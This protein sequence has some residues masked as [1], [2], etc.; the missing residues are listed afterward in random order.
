MT[1]PKW[2]RGFQLY[3]RRT[4][5]DSLGN[6]MAFYDMEQPDAEVSPENGVSFQ[7]P[8]A[9]NPSGKLSSAGAQVVE[10]GEVM[11]GV[12]GCYLR[13]DLAVAEYDRI[14]VDGLLYEVRSIQTWPG[15]RKL[16]LQRLD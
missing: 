1:P 8:R 14:A 9:W 4:G 12:M 10:Y 15:H 11:G 5:T 13:D 2:R 6:E 16:L 7:R 3:R